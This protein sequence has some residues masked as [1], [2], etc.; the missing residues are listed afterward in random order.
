MAIP[1][2]LV[3]TNILL[4]ISRRSDPQQRLVDA[5]LHR[6]ANAGTTFFYTHQNIAELW[7]VMT[8][9]AA[10]NGFGLTIAE[11]EREVQVIE[12]G[13]VLLPENELV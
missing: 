4:R 3:D 10:N 8:R 7:N 6:L 13:M 1:S 2:C 11:A 5:A 12:S 9:P